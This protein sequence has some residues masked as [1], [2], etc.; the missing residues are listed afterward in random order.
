MRLGLRVDSWRGKTR[1]ALDVPVAE[2][3]WSETYPKLPFGRL[4][5][6]APADWYPEVVSDPLMPMGQV[7]RAEVLA[8][9]AVTPLPPCRIVDVSESSGGVSVTADSIDLAIVEDDWA[10][11]SSPASGARL[12]DEAARLASPLPVRLLVPN[13]TLPA[14]LVWSGGRDDALLELAVM[15][16]G[17][18]SLDVDGTLTLVPLG[19]SLDPHR[20]YDSMHVVDAARKTSRSR[21]SKAT[22]V[23]QAQQGETSEVLTRTLA[24]A[25]YQPDVYGVV[26]KVETVQAGMSFEQRAAAARALLEESGT[27]RAFSILADP[28]LRAGMVARTIVDRRGYQRDVFVG[29]VM[30]TTLRSSG[31]HEITVKGDSRG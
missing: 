13:A 21:V 5:L 22:V 30:A 10:L 31:A 7:L 23:T 25:E 26:G 19:N 15:H 2:W 20:T 6:T 27:E 28:S 24:D 3:A 1:L 9:R 14:G 29:R 16:G 17:R 8:D 12:A 11:P 18:W 4:T